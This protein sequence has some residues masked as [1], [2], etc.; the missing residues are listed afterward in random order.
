MD[1][2]KRRK[3]SFNEDS[4]CFCQKSFKKNKTILDTSKSQS[5]FAAC[6]KRNDEISVNIVASE[7]RILSGEVKLCYHKSCRSKFIHPFYNKGT[8]EDSLSEKPES[9]SSFT[10]SQVQSNGFTWKENCFICG[11]SKSSIKYRKAWSKVEGTINETSRLYAK[12]L[13]ISELKGD[14]ELHSR[15]LS[16]KGDLVAVEA[17]YHRNKGC[18]SKYIADRNIRAVQVSPKKNQSTDA[19]VILKGQIKEKIETEKNV[20]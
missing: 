15:L 8:E 6:R 18:L 2:A 20:C 9:L 7:E 19:C 17:R 13:E 12:L 4:C 11:D 1:N 5:L 14:N 10:R 16:S 3:L